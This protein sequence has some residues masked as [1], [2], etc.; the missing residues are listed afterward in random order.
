[1]VPVE[2]FQQGGHQ[3]L[4]RN[5]LLVMRVEND[6]GNLPVLGIALE[7]LVSGIERNELLPEEITFLIG[8]NTCPHASH[9][10]PRLDRGVWVCF[11]VV[12][13]RRVRRLSS[14]RGHDGDTVALLVVHQWR[15]PLDPA[16]RTCVIEQKDPRSGPAG[17]MAADPAARSPVESHMDL[18][19]PPPKVDAV[20]VGEL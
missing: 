20:L 18:C 19:R 6:D 5:G 12:E 3:L 10:G 8:R 2:A 16:L 7:K 4:V 14:L 9:Q 1:M 11:Q 15:R 13:P 17:K